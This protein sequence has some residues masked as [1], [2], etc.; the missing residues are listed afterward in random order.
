VNRGAIKIA[1]ALSTLTGAIFQRPPSTSAVRR[2]LRVR[3]IYFNKLIDYDD[4][5]NLAV[6]WTSCE[7]GTYIR[8]LCYHLGLVLGVG[9]YMQELRRIRSGTLGENDNMVTMHDVL[10]AMWLLDNNN[11]ES[12][13]RRIVMPLEVLLIKHKRILIKDSAVNAICYGARLTVP[14]LLRYEVVFELADTV[15]IMTTKGEA[16]AVGV[17]QMNTAMLSSCNHG[18]VAT[19]KRVIMEKDVYPRRWGLSS[20]IKS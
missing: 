8:S 20:V 5:R 18:I 1:K 9:G 11:D 6:I 12:Y 4:Q 3:T 14:G 2:H 17:A 13:L 16:V 7:S 19:T 15:V 10:D